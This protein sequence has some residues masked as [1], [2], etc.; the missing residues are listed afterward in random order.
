[1]SGVAEARIR[2]P[3]ARFRWAKVRWLL[4]RKLET[5]DSSMAIDD[6]RYLLLLPGCLQL[7]EHPHQ[8]V[9]GGL[10]E[11]LL[12]RSRYGNYGHWRTTLWRH[13]ARV[14]CEFADRHGPTAAIG[15]PTWRASSSR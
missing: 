12:Q 6:A 2:L 8:R 11:L 3:P 15:A 13:P 14:K 4:I 9:G 7:L 5:I 1:M 10:P